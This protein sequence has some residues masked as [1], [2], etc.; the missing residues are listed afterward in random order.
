MSP[1]IGAS[2]S[3][4]GRYAC[5]FWRRSMQSPW[6]E[7]RPQPGS[8]LRVLSP[9]YKTATVVDRRALCAPPP[10]TVVFGNGPNTLAVLAELTTVYHRWPWVVPCVAVAIDQGSLEA[11]LMLISELRDCLGV[12]KQ[13][14]RNAVCEPSVILAAIRN[15]RAP[16]A[17]VLTTWA[18]RRLD[19]LDLREAVAC[20]F[21]EA[22]GGPPASETAS[23]STYSRLF[24]RFGPYTARDWRAIARLCVH[25]VAIGSF[26]TTRALPMRT[27]KH[28]LRMYLHLSHGTLADR[29][30]WE[31]VLE[32]AL[33]VGHYVETPP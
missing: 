29:V 26:E 20:Q 15:R 30:G 27:A 10:G 22:L 23:A 3:P 12:V 4:R 24:A 19:N 32:G 21:R 5:S 17:E 6:I 7:F 1:C 9:P 2:F 33:R 11:L 28:Y 18:G 16:D 31:W 8:Q 13:A 14:H 25:C